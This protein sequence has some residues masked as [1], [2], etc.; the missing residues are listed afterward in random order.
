VRA[1]EDVVV[2]KD[3]S[4]LASDDACAVV[5]MAEKGGAEGG[6]KQHTRTISN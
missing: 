6:W 3:V 4:M 2:A 5:V 1:T